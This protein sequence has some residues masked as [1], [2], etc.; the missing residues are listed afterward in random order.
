MFVAAIDVS[1]FG[2][3]Q[4]V[5]TTIGEQ[6]ILFIRQGEKFYAIDGV[7][8]HKGAWMRDGIIDGNAITCPWHDA[9][10]D[11]RNGNGLNPMASGG[12][13]C[14]PTRVNDQVI[15]IDLGATE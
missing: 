11:F 9:Q 8:P 4:A 14:W 3:R 12:I 13:R 2:L 15:E 5:C 7:C 10:F 1:E 6:L